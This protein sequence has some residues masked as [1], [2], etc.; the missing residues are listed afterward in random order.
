MRRRT[1]P[2][3]LVV[4]VIVAIVVAVARHHGPAPRPLPPLVPHGPTHRA[5]LGPLRALP[6]GL[7]GI[8]GEAI[9]STSVWSNPRFLS[10]VAALRPQAIRVFGGTPANFWNWRTG[11]YDHS[12]RIPSG[13]AA[14]RDHIHVSLADW[15]RLVRV[16]GAVP[17]FDLNIYSSSL[18]SQ[19]AM[20]HAARRLGMP[21]N[22]VELGN[23][24][25]L[26][27][28]A[29]RFPSGAQYGRVATRW[30]AAIKRAFPAVL[31]AADAYPGRDTNTAQVN[32][33]ER[34]WNSE[35]LRTLRGE[36]A[37]SLHAYFASGLGPHAS[38]ASPAAAERMLRAP[39]HRWAALMRT[40]ARLPRRLEV[41][42][43]EWNLFDTVARVHGTWAQ[44]LAVASFGLD[45]VSAPR[46]VQADYETLVDSAPFGAIFGTTAGLQL[47]T[48]NGGGF[49]A[50]LA[51]APVTPLFGLATGGVV[52]QT[53]LHALSGA[54]VSR[55]MSFGSAPVRGI[56]VAGKDGVGAVLVN[57][58]RRPFR[59]AVPTGLRGLPYG[60]RSAPPITL[61]AGAGTLENRAGTTTSDLE[62]APF[63]L[64][65]IGNG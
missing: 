17:V 2:A 30:I 43:T 20:L 29:G 18:S 8:N 32:G 6:P 5:T 56:A 27:T 62:L 38:L 51:H 37:L 12:P 61:V 19:L 64:L 59:I 46:V 42:V 10:A 39:A 36:S 23:E 35:M 7:L 55:T 4:L 44:G 11:T 26:P 15:A 65:R 25:Y 60:E 24:L 13:L 22:E 16:T 52:M 45:L 28:Y 63:S 47:A 31:V 14:L 49:R 54:T 41:W 21:I 40:I 9:I 48:G 1:V 53:L 34:R 33:R 57:L 58:S 50:V 3:I